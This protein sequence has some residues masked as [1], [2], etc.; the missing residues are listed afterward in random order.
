MT[1]IR[2]QYGETWYVAATCYPS[3]LMAKNAW[4]HANAKLKLAPGEDGCGLTRLA[5]N[6]DE[7]PMIPSGIPNDALHAVVCV[8]TDRRV[9]DKAMRLLRG[10]TEWDPV[11]EF[12]DT[13]IARRARMMKGRLAWSLGQQ[14]GGGQVVIRRPE[15]HG[16]RV[17][18]SG[19][20]HE[21]GFRD[22]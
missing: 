19:Q 5:P 16:A 21:G 15:D 10:G 14:K 12:C 22:A 1:V 2:E 3:A 4:E 13:L 7:T 6:P 8:T 11:D 17:F 20:V 9:L 18:E